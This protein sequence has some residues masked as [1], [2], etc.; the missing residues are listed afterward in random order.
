MDKVASLDEIYR[1]L[2][3]LCGEA[4]ES[5]ELLIT[6]VCEEKTPV[7]VLRGIKDIA[8]RL[9]AKARSDPHRNVATLLYHA[10]IAAAE[11]HAWG[12]PSGP[13]HKF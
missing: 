13:F 1:L 5:G 10:A 4:E 6:T 7:E 11:A 2:S 3:E 8:K 12:E 9:H